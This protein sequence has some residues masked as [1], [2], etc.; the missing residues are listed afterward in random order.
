MAAIIDFGEPFVK[1]TYRLD[2]DGP[3]ALECFE[4]VEGSIHL[5]YAPNVEAVAKS[6]S[7]RSLTAKQK[8]IDHAKKCV[9]P[10][11]T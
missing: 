2:D 5:G 11:H 9:K 6:I 4:V 8:L 1:A 3:L 10:G 7:K